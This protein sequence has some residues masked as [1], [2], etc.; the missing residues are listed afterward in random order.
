MGQ[1]PESDAY[2]FDGTGLPFLQG[3]ADFGYISPATSAYCV[4]PPKTAAPGAV[5]V[6]VR[7]PVGTLN[8][9]QTRYGIGRGLCA[10]SA[11]DGITTAKFLYYSL[12]GFI[13]DLARESTGSTY[14]AVSASDV[15]NLAL[16]V[17]S[18]HSQVWIPGYLDRQTGQI[19]ELVKTK[20][21][22]IELLDEKRAAL[23]SRAVTQGLDPGVPMKDSGVAWLGCIPA[24]WSA[25]K[26][27]Y[28]SRIF[29]PARDKPNLKDTG[30]LR[31]FPW[32][33]LDEVRTSASITRSVATRWVEQT[34]LNASGGRVLPAG[35]VIASCVGEFGL[36]AIADDPC[37]V[38]QQL[39]AYA[40]PIL[41]AEFLRHCV[42]AGR[43]YFESVAT[44]TTIRYINQD[45]FANLPLPRP[46]LDEQR[47]I[48]SY[49]K[50]LEL[51]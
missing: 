28:V 45:R 36:S 10:V 24:H 34:D 43:Q 3:C 1:S 14:D 38:N 5:L 16:W 19:D 15:G 51:E 17:P 50:C 32:I 44:T 48:I 12:A 9:A 42:E 41:N 11:K 2:N 46:T 8:I 49:I 47:Q 13:S 7:A 35:S 33:T 6:S 20:V 21:R 39:Q 29:V 31:D 22:L 25:P 27:K 30:D 37:V 18:V 26:A 40:R 23:I 4:R